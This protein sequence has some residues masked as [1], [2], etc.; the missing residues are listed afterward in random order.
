MTLA[1]TKKTRVEKR[2]INNGQFKFCGRTFNCNEITDRLSVLIAFNSFRDTDVEVFDETGHE[3][4]S[5][6]WI[7]LEVSNGTAK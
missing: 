7:G 1:A 4:G 2:I 5:A 6:Q 3:L